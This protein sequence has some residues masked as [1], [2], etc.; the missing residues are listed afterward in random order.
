M[1]HAN[2]FLGEVAERS[3]GV[4][5]LSDPAYVFF[6]HEPPIYNSVATAV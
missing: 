5:A 4:A 2:G 1:A 3:R 6:K